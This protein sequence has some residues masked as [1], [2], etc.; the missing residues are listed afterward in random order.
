M[1]KEEED[2]IEIIKI[3]QEAGVYFEREKSFK[4]LRGNRY[5]YDFYLPYVVGGPVIIE[6]DGQLHWS[7]AYGVD[8][9]K[10]QKERDRRKNSYALANGI[11][12]YRIPYWDIDNNSIKNLENILSNK[13]KVTSKWHN[14]YLEPK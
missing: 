12:L 1:N 7:A 14:D 11:K 3:L 13:Y 4:D 5:R 9:L 2:E 6:V 10:T 8:K